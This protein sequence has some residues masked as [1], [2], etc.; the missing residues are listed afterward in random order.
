M[1]YYPQLLICKEKWFFNF[2]VISEPFFFI[3][4]VEV[5][6]TYQKEKKPQILNVQL[7][8]FGKYVVIQ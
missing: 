2:S 4:F 1:A 7:Y 6:F 5:N 8:E 3:S